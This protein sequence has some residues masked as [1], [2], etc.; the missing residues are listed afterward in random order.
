MNFLIS[1]VKAISDTQTLFNEHRNKICADL[2]KGTS[3]LGSIA[4]GELTEDNQKPFYDACESKGEE[5]MSGLQSLEHI[6]GAAKVSIHEL[7]LKGNETELYLPSL[8]AATQQAKASL[9]SIG[10]WTSI[11]IIISKAAKKKLP[12]AAVRA[13]LGL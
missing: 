10:C 12:D 4:L 9:L 13:L 3:A 2:D 5:L 11:K 8:G 1:K 6:I 7:K